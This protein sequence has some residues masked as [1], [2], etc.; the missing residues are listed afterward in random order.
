[1][2]ETSVMSHVADAML[3]LVGGRSDQGRG[4]A[5]PEDRAA[6]AQRTAAKVDGEELATK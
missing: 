3:K 1:M 2:I 5:T 4:K 6:C